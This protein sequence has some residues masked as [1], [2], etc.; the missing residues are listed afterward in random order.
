MCSVTVVGREQA[1]VRWRDIRRIIRARTRPGRPEPVELHCSSRASTGPAKWV[2]SGLPSPG[3][4]GV[5]HGVT[6][7][8]C[9]T[10]WSGSRGKPE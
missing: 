9:G 10:G 1:W 3:T 7:S 2:N 8:L 6:G 4:P 5:G